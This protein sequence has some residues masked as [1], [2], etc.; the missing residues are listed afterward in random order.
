MVLTRSIADLLASAFDQ[1]RFYRFPDPAYDA[2]KQ[3]L[4]LYEIPPVSLSHFYP[5]HPAFRG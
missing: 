4:P 1:F 3:A 2:F 5:P